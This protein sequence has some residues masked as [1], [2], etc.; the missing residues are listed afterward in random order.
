TS[1]TTHNITTIADYSIAIHNLIL[2]TIIAGVLCC[3]A[4]GKP[5]LHKRNIII[6]L[7]IIGLAT[8]E[9]Q[10]FLNKYA[11]FS[12]ISDIFP[13]QTLVTHLQK[14]AG[15]NRIYGYNGA[16]ISANLPTQWRLQY[17]EGY[18]SF[19]PKLY[20][21][22]LAS[23]VHGTY[24]EIPPR[25]DANLANTS[26]SQDS[27][28]KQVVMNLLDI[29]Y[30]V[31]EDNNLPTN[32]SPQTNI[33]FPDRFKLVW[34][35]SKWQI[36]QNLET[37]PRVTIYY[38]WQSINNNKQIIATL[39]NPT[40]DYKNKLIVSSAFNTRPTNISVNA[41][42][43][44]HYSANK[45][46]ISADAKANGLLFLPDTYFPDW[47]AQ[48]DGKITPIIR[49]D[50]AFRSVFISKGHHTIVFTYQPTGFNIGIIISGVSIII[51]IILLGLFTLKK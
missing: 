5:F 17:P 43:V 50:Y 6:F 21:Q 15:N 40:F 9:Y 46:I 1:R 16:Y 12:P 8:F 4:I 28:A 18:D 47:I 49:S 7:I 51:S 39:F 20:G 44:I 37:Q 13:Q 25:S 3:L 22:L 23:T 48:V 35:Q 27:Y 11:S 10:Y 26:P 31:N 45:I 19:Y 42:K 29:K 36:Y 32:W 33:F 14:I 38:N 34:Q 41:A 30:V 2:P 24:V